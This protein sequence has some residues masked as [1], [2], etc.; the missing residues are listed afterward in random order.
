VAA[1]RMA[2]TTCEKLRIMGL[3]GAVAA[4]PVR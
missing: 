4:S 2:A 3:A 1:L